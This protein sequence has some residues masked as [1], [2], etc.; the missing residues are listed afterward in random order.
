MAFSLYS[1]DEAVDHKYVVIKN[2][3]GQVKK[4]TLIHIMDADESSDGITVNYRVTKTKQDLTANFETIKQFC[5][6]CMPS[7]FL[8]KYYDKLSTREIMRF[9]QAENRTF[10]TYQLPIILVCLV[11]VW[12][13]TIVMIAMNLVG[14]TLGLILGGGLSVVCIVGV[15]VITHLAKNRMVESLYEKVSKHQTYF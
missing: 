6:W 5:T 3:K 2:M 8:A 13:A 9:I 11:I 7:T 10:V 1:I 15:L 4:G 14:S 12:A